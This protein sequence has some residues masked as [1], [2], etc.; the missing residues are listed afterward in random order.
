[1]NVVY[2]LLD[3][4]YN[5]GRRRYEDEM[6]IMEIMNIFYVL[7]VVRDGGYVCLKLV[8]RYGGQRRYCFVDEFDR[9]QSEGMYIDSLFKYFGMKCILNSLVDFK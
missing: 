8:F 6:K 2:V 4:K 1:M 7:L 5:C 3:R 9:S